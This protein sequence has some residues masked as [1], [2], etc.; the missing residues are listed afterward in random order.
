[1]CNA[2]RWT[3]PGS[4][5][6]APSGH[7]GRIADDHP[8][9]ASDDDPVAARLPGLADRSLTEPAPDRLAHDHPLRALIL[10]AHL[11]ALEAG[12]PSYLDPATGRQ[13]L[14]AARLVLNGQCCDSGCRHC[15]WER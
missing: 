14:T 13:V 9:Q 5:H 4:N 12:E 10:A 7:T 1:M 15:P 2:E 6:P 8:A 3:A 11:T